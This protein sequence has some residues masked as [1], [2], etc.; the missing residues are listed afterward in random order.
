MGW[1]T[2][3]YLIMEILHYGSL[4][5]DFIMTL[6]RL[7]KRMRLML[8]ENY[9]YI[10]TLRDGNFSIKN[11]KVLDMLYKQVE[12]NVIININDGYYF[13]RYITNDN[14]KQTFNPEFFEK[15]NVL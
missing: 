11:D 1:I 2:N 4:R 9:I 5:K 12:N 6:F 13:P 7:S 14:G 10:L 15:L 3:K 8:S